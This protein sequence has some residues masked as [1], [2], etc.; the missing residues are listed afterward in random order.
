[1]IKK[2]FAKSQPQ[3]VSRKELHIQ[4]HQRTWIQKGALLRNMRQ[5]AEI[6]VPE[7][8]RRL[9]VS[10]GRLYRFEAGNPVREAK[11]IEAS[12]LHVFRYSDIKNLL[13]EVIEIIKEEEKNGISQAQHSHNN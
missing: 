1:M 4:E 12:Y 6:S 2:L 3:L 11:L 8:A 5:E 13:M 10:P 9:N 7:M